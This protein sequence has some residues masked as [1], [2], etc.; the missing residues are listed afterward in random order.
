MNIDSNS[1]KL[2]GNLGLNN[3]IF[4]EAFGLSLKSETFSH[5]EFAIFVTI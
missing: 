3:K 5:F 2:L 1:T 4:V